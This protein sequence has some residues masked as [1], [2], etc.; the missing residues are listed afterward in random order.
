MARSRDPSGLPGL[1]TATNRSTSGADMYRGNDASFQWANLGTA[2]I[3]WPNSRRTLP[4]N[5]KTSEWR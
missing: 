1:H 4:G 5:V 2:P 3:S